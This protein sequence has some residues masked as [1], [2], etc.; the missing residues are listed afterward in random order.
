[1]VKC[2]SVFPSVVS[3]FSGGKNIFVLYIRSV[4]KIA[5]LSGEGVQ[6][7]RGAYGVLFQGTA[8]TFS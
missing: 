2:D 5:L 1:M 6:V 7:P 3:F 4:S 8:S